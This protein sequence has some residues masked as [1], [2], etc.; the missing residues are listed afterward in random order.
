MK[1]T[2]SPVWRFFER[3]Q[4]DGRCI[5]VVC[6]LCENQYKFFGNTTNLRVHLTNKHPIQWELSE[7]GNYDETSVQNAVK[8]ETPVETR[9]YARKKKHVT[10]NSEQNVGYSVSVSADNNADSTAGVLPQIEIQ[11]VYIPKYFQLI[12]PKS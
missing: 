6:K 5:A 4:E 7:S 10:R 11:R 2:S 9:S 8:V 1:K 3:I 12:N